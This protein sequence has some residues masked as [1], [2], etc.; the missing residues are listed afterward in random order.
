MVVYIKYECIFIL[1]WYQYMQYMQYINHIFK[2]IYNTELKQNQNPWLWKIETLAART[3]GLGGQ[4]QLVPIIVSYRDNIY[5]SMNYIDGWRFLGKSAWPESFAEFVC[6]R[7]PKPEE[8]QPSWPIGL[9][10]LPSADTQQLSWN[11]LWTVLIPEK[12]A[13]LSTAPISKIV[14][15]NCYSSTNYDLW[16]LSSL[17][18]VHSR[19]HHVIPE[20]KYRTSFRDTPSICRCDHHF[21]AGC[22]SDPSN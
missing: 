18:K 4:L 2:I 19:I 9:K 22:K 15:P 16:F 5:E 3:S 11:T 6:L 17:L 7:S 12:D 21:F 1:V 13:N 10:C 8:Y 20:K 14:K